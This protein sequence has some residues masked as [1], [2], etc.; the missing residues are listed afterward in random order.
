MVIGTSFDIRPF[1]IYN[2]YMPV[3][4][5]S[6]IT[7]HLFES[8]GLLIA[9]LA[10]VWAVMRV[11]GR[12]TENKKLMHASWASLVLLGVVWLIASQVTTK[13][14]QLEAA[15]GDLLLAVEDKDMPAF[16]D[17]VLPD[18][19]TQFMGRD[20]TRDQVEARIN[21]A[22]IDDLMLRSAVVALHENEPEL[23]TTAIRVRAE[24]AVAEAQGMEFSEWFIRWKYVDG[25]W[26]ALLLVC[27]KIG[28]DA[29]FDNG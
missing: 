19:T 29:I 7:T 25:Q 18:S 21:E 20:L 12:R 14:E 10:I 8:P 4:A 3:F 1:I 9:G 24:G 11:A 28:P 6:A 5:Q 13:R 17:I 23:G 26:K 15:L 16:R 2:S 22:T 27:E